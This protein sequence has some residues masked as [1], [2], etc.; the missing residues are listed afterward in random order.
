M[1]CIIMYVYVHMIIIYMFMIFF[2]VY[3]LIVQEYGY[4]ELV[5]QS[6]SPVGH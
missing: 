3:R 2:L 4:C 1:I 6:Q 5:T